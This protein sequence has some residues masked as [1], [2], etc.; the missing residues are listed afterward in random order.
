MN[1]YDYMITK[2]QNAKK[3]SRELAYISTEVKNKALIAMSEALISNKALILSE[4]EKDLVNGRNNGMSKALL[5]RLALNVKRIED[6]AEGLKS[7]ASLSDPIGEVTKMWRNADNLQI[8]QVRVPLGVIG[9]IYEA[10]PNVTVDSAALCIKS[11]NAVI[12]KGGKEALNSNITIADIITRAA[13]SS[14]LPEGSIQLIETADREA[15]NTMMKLNEYIDVLIPRGGS[16][17]IQSVVKNSTVPVIQTGV[18]NCHVYVDEYADF[19]MAEKIVINAKTQRPAVCNAMETLLVHKNAAEI[20]LP[21]VSDALK[22]YGVEIRGCS[23]TEKY[24]S[25]ISKATEEDWKTEYGD[26]II[27]VKIVASIDEAMD[28]I[29]KYG[30]KHSEA[31]ITNNYKNSQRFLQEVDA[32][33]VYVNASTR[34]TD[35][36]QFGFGGEI[37]I[38]TQK[39]HARGPMGLEQLTSIKYIIY[40]EGQC[41]K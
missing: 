15:T 3:A 8:G 26:L 13:V 31:I 41:R 10:R 36:G 33:A 22:T 4:N 2:G 12:L 21:K 17:L 7:I 23:E 25:N 39:L 28:H 6:M 37:G 30:T 1:I 24:V 5:D 11:G 38:S 29:Y 14:G 27:A 9:I 18:G 35:G 16:G 19:D 40:G 34:F 20:F 32:A